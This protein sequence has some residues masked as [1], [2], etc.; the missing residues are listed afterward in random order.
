[1]GK[2]RA[3]YIVGSDKVSNSKQFKLDS[4]KNIIEIDNPNLIQLL[5]YSFKTF[6]RQFLFENAKGGRANFR[7]YFKKLFEEY[8]KATDYKF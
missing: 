7:G 8:N 2:D 5:N 3:Y 4:S 6:P 1:M